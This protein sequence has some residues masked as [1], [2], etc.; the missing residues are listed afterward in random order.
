MISFGDIDSSVEAW[1][2]QGFIL[3]NSWTFYSAGITIFLLCCH[4][5]LVK[6][7]LSP[8][9]IGL[10]YHLGKFPSLERDLRELAIWSCSPGQHFSQEWVTCLFDSCFRDSRSSSPN[11]GAA[12]T[13]QFPLNMAQ[14]LAIWEGK[15]ILLCKPHTLD[16]YCLLPKCLMRLMRQ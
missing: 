12:G 15:H 5:L 8:G 3:L 6:L 10:P 11:G 14:A 2:Y 7:L 4:W 1:W 9:S 13:H 16:S